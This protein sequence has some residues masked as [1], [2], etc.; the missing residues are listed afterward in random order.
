MIIRQE[1]PD[2]VADLSDLIRAAFAC[3]Q[4]ADLVDGL[5]RGG[6]LLLSL[7][8]EEAGRVIGHVGFSR[9]WISRDSQRSPGVSLAPLAVTAE[10]RRRGVGAALVEAGHGHLRSA[11][12]SICFVLGDP[13]YYGRFG[14]SIPAAAA[15]DC[16]YA[17]VHFQA[18]ALKSSAPKAGAISYAAAFAGL[19]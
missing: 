16:V 18:L 4:E 17:G 10:Y 12:E 11:G 15:F 2:D 7:V 14:Y 3:H 6:D 13:A 1:T 9:V 8:A 5:R 19:N